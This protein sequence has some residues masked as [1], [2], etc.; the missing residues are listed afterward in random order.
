MKSASAGAGLAER[1]AEVSGK[2]KI[3]LQRLKPRRLHRGDA[4]SLIAPS[5]SA[6]GPDR[7]EASIRALSNLG[8]RVKA[9]PHCADVYGYLAGEDATRARELEL[10][11]LDPDT[12]AVICLKGGYGTPRI[13]DLIDYS[14]IAAHPK[15][16]L[17]YSDITALHIAFRQRAG[18]VTFHGPMPS[19]DMVPEFNPES[20]ASLEAALFGDPKAARFGDPEASSSVRRVANPGDRPFRA[21]SGGIAEGELAGGNLSLLVATLGT[22]WEIDAEGKIILIE[23]VDEAPYRIDR[24]MNQLRLAG[25]F[26]ACAGVAI[27]SWTRC[28][29]SEG[30]RSLAIEEI[31]RDLVL[32]SGKPILAGLEA[33]HCVPTLTLPFGVRYRM[34]VEALSLKLLE[35]PFADEA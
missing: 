33:G 13:L 15:T 25:K 21:I 12:S 28:S 6:S 1:T 5:G 27:G 24:M 30:K 18:L 20:R 8:F 14:I 17:G 26:E 23:D 16:F 29:P 9:S 19:S 35:D 3:A 22:P 32:P 11:F 34:D 31:I 4:V 2:H 7:I 10:A